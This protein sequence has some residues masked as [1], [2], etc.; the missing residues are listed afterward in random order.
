MYHSKKLVAKLS[1]E[2]KKIDCCMQACILYYKNNESATQYKFC[3]EEIYCSIRFNGKRKKIWWNNC[4]ICH[5]LQDWKD[6]LLQ[7]EL[8]KKWDDIMKIFVVLMSFLTL[9][10]LKHGNFLIEYIQTLGLIQEMCWWICSIWAIWEVFFLLVS[11]CY[12]L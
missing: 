12:S 3:G 1:L 7:K 4:S 8:Q 10:M 6:C 9:L 5:L 2:Y 11:N